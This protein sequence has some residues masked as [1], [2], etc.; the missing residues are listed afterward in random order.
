MP[1]NKREP[2]NAKSNSHEPGHGPEE[3]L[4]SWSSSEVVGVTA[5][6][7]QLNVDTGLEQKDV[8]VAW[9]WINS[10]V[11]ASHM[12]KPSMLCAALRVRWR[13]SSRWHRNPTL[14][15]CHVHIDLIRDEWRQVAFDDVTTEAEAAARQQAIHHGIRCLRRQADQNRAPE[16]GL[17]QSE[18]RGSDRSDVPANPEI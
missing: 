15:T 7:E 9:P 16:L 1:P 5:I 14:I 10:N 6:T 3:D 4:L 13:V 11:P 17:S 18:S 8:N 12:T 2:N